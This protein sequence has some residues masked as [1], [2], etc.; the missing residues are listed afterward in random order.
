MLSVIKTHIF[1][2]GRVMARSCLLIY[3]TD[4][5]RDQPQEHISATSLGGG[6]AATT[7]DQPQGILLHGHGGGELTTGHQPQKNPS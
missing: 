4:T 2:Q 7:F 3:R 6:G 5:P 1:A